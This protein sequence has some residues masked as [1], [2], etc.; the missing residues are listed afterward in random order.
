MKFI[1]TLQNSIICKL[2]QFAADYCHK[3]VTRI[4]FIHLILKIS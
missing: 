2:L 3:I 1:S 4:H